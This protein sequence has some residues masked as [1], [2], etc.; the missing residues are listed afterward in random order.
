[1]LKDV[2]IGL[3]L[4]NVRSGLGNML[5]IDLSYAFDAPPGIKRTQV[6]VETKSRF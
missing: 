2:G 5:H 4:G 6:T 1:M 3:R